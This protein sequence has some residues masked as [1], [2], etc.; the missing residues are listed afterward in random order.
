[1][2]RLVVMGPFSVQIQGPGFWELTSAAPNAS[3][4]YLGGVGAGVA[5]AA[6]IDWLQLEWRADGVA[7]ELSSAGGLRR[8]QGKAALV[9]E[10]R[11]RLYDSL[12][13]A[14]FDAR[15]RRF[16]RRVFIL[17]RIPGG[18]FLLGMMARGK[19]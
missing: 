11:A 3:R 19:R 8:L 14:D 6:P 5:L 1:M 7:V 9:H 2:T 10:T 12:P 4:V 18:R 17:M 16:W 15:A 13:L